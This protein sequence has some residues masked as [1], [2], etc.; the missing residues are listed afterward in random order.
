MNI[1]KRMLLSVLYITAVT[2]GFYINTWCGIGVL[3]V[4]AGI[5]LLTDGRGT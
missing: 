3:L 2:L 1:I 4:C 5:S